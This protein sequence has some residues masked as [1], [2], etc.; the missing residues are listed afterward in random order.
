M[1]ESNTKEDLVVHWDMG[2]NKKRIGA[3][4]LLFLLNQAALFGS[5]FPLASQQMPAENELRAGTIFTFWRGGFSLLWP[6]SALY[7]RSFGFW[8][9]HHHVPKY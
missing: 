6:C 3:C 2:L 1:K 9:C 5:H 7:A 4:T 8:S